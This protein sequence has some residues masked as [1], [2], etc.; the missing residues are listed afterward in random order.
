[1]FRGRVDASDAGRTGGYAVVSDGQAF[2][3]LRTTA[4]LRAAQGQVITLRRDAQ[5]R[6]LVVPGPDRDIGR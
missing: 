2:V 6:L 3:V 4:T 5:G 1:V